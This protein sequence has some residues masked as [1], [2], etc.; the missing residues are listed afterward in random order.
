MKAAHSN[1]DMGSCRSSYSNVFARKSWSSAIEIIIGF[2]VSYILGVKIPAAD[3]ELRQDELFIEWQLS[4]TVFK[5]S[6]RS[7][8]TK[9]INE[10][11]ILEIFYRLKPFVYLGQIQML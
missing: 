5:F 2:L 9:L 4:P 10:L 8:N 7:L 1:E 3:A 6:V 11:F